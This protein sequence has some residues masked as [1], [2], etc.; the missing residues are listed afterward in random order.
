MNLHRLGLTVTWKI[1]SHLLIIVRPIFR[2][3]VSLQQQG[4]SDHCFWWDPCE[5]H[6]HIQHLS[7]DQAHGKDYRRHVD[8]WETD[9]PEFPTNFTDPTHIQHV[10][11]VLEAHCPRTGWRL[12][13]PV[14]WHEIYRYTYSPTI[15]IS[16]LAQYTHTTFC[17]FCWNTHAR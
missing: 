17:M 4:K 8:T 10:Q 6:L 1:F 15:H 9:F 13:L 14:V 3:C 5:H 16:T 12:I 11:D 7:K 2:P